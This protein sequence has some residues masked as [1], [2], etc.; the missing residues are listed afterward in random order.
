MYLSFDDSYSFVSRVIHLWLR[1]G[2]FFTTIYLFLF[3]GFCFTRGFRI[4]F[5]GV[6]DFRADFFICRCCCDRLGLIFFVSWNFSTLLL[7]VVI[8][9]DVS[10]IL[11]HRPFYFLLSILLAGVFFVRICGSG[12]VWFDF[13]W[14]Y[15]FCWTWV[16][17]FLFSCLRGAWVAF[18]FSHVVFGYRFPFSWFWWLWCWF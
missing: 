4:V 1:V 15:F 13:D 7:I 18:S 8:F 12:W 2:L 11:G 9:E 10:F 6:F 14:V 3:L 16:D 17:G 5:V